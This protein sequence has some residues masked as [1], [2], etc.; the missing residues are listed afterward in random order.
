MI[1]S[2]TFAAVLFL[3]LA[4]PSSSTAQIV[5]V[6]SAGESSMVEQ[7]LELSARFYGLHMQT[8]TLQ[9]KAGVAT[10]ISWISN[11]DTMGVAITTVAL[12]SLQR[13]QVMAA[14]RR[15]GGQPIP[16]LILGA[17]ALQE[18]SLIA[19]W[20]NGDLSGC[21]A[22]SPASLDNTYE[23]GAVNDV[24]R[25]LAGE[26]IPVVTEAAC[27][28]VVGANRTVEPLI[29]AVQLTPAH[30]RSAPVFVRT[31]VD[32]TFYLADMRL[33]GSQQ[34]AAQSLARIFSEIAPMMMFVRHAAG[35]RAWHSVG[36][37]ANLS[38]DDA[39][40][41]E[42]YGHLNYAGLVDEM[43]R[44]NFHTTISF[45]PWN[46][47]R[48][49][50]DAVSI[51]KNHNNRLSVSVHG[52]NHDHREFA[53][54]GSV[55]LNK[56]ITNIQQALARMDRFSALT[57]VSYDP[58]MVFPHATGPEG[59]LTELK[60]Y[61]FLATAYSL[62]LPLG[63]APPSDPLFY[64]R[65]FNLD[66]A[67]FPGL[68][69]YFA[70][71]P[72]ARVE[73]AIN[74]FLENPLLFYGHEKLFNSGIRS[75]NKIADAVNDVQ[76]GTHWCSLG[77]VTQHLY[78][79]KL[80]DDGNLDTEIFS[81]QVSL[82]NRESRDRLFLVKKPEN[83]IPAVASITVDGQQQ[84]FV[85][86]EGYISTKVFVPAGQTRDL[87]IEYANSWNVASTDIS[88]QGLRV[89]LL[90]RVSDFRDLTLSRYSWGRA[91]TAF[92]YDGGLNSFELKIEK[93]I[94]VIIAVM[95]LLALAAVAHFAR[96]RKMIR[97]R[98]R[99]VVRH[100]ITRVSVS[101]K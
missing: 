54:F 44:H 16:L 42:P 79:V 71:K 31:S 19:E 56:Q 23:F 34:P 38:I 13:S 100:P 52:N 57:G 43:E 66:F 64:L 68:K 90:R 41:V 95:F 93:N 74:A 11:K 22:L 67:N 17:T 25:Q 20:S 73:L 10:A 9:A 80:R 78:R 33:A 1:R 24:T 6:R 50:A 84:P 40:L 99:R 77:C 7:R 51:F 37:Y 76:P 59:T 94:P 60:R 49:Q 81:S 92:Y 69:R 101:S 89:A 87:R 27:S 45:I 61:E 85:K 18:P 91:L 28:F 15:S 70:E 53:D 58:V 48:S 35:D 8:I 47:D 98:A 2:S 46:F 14:L 12:P 72:V 62:D 4:L 32:P 29:S 82:E 5:F 36:H 39:W 97:L 63:A 88:K 65:T 83:F 96:R 75:F 3:C 30:D 21:Q 55:P 26:R 86:G